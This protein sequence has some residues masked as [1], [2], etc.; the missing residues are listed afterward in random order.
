MFKEIW[1]DKQITM[2]EIIFNER[3]Y[4]FNNRHICMFMCL[5]WQLSCTNFKMDGNREVEMRKK[6]SSI[7]QEREPQ[8]F[9][10]NISLWHSVMDNLQLKWEIEVYIYND[11]NQFRLLIRNIFW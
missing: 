1:I 8:T 10:T 6:Y 11:L 2:A 3:K 5:E 4:N 9:Y 7:C